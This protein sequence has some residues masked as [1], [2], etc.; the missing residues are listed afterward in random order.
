MY[1]LKAKYVFQYT[2]K[3]INLHKFTWDVILYARLYHVL[4]YYKNQQRGSYRSQIGANNI[5]HYTISNSYSCTIIWILKNSNNKSQHFCI[6][7]KQSETNNTCTSVCFVSTCHTQ[8][9][10]K[11]SNSID[12]KCSIIFKQLPRCENT[13]RNSSSSMPVIF[14]GFLIKSSKLPLSQSSITI[15]SF[16]L[17][18]KH[19][20]KNIL[21]SIN[22]DIIELIWWIKWIITRGSQEL[23][24]PD[25]HSYKLHICINMLLQ[26]FHR[27]NL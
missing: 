12:S 25:Y 4:K 14:S 19:K 1:F 13:L 7:A 2:S 3:Y 22:N 15:T 8:I 10:A 6:I 5:Y 26:W 17:H 18:W 21:K 11:I 24:S 23:V 16:L 20:E 27:I 9:M